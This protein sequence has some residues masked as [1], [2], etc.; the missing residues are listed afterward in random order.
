MHAMNLVACRQ[1]LKKPQLEKAV[2]FFFQNEEAKTNDSYA[3]WKKLGL[4]YGLV[5][6]FFS[7][8][9]VLEKNN[10]VVGAIY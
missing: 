5:V 9:V 8:L 10:I 2:V 6:F 4:C 1:F 3:H 7:F